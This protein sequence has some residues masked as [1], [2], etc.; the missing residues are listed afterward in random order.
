MQHRITTSP[1][2]PSVPDRLLLP[3][4]AT[5]HGSTHWY[6]GMLSALLPAIRE[7]L[8]LTYAQ[9][10]LLMTGRALLGACGNVATSIAADMGGQRRSILIGSVFMVALCSVFLGMSS[11]LMLIFFG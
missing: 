1:E 4:I 5:G 10:G 8:G 2:E 6:A 9:I 3:L 11:L 7:D